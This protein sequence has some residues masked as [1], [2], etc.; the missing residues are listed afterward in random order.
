MRLVAIGRLKS[1][2]ERDLFERYA[3]RLR[4]A[5][6]VTELPPS[7]GSVLEQK[8][9]D[10]A[11]LLGACPDNAIVVAL[12][13]GGKALSSLKFAAMMERWQDSG[14]PIHFLIGGAEGLDSSVIERA[15]AVLSLGALTWPHMLVR[16]MIAE[17]I[18][19]AQAINT[20][21]PYHRDTRPD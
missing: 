3:A 12:D 9:R 14:R 18:F 19:R 2:P 20:G 10:A 1:G 4:P 11:A 17:Q 8:R 21:H 15:D 6:E 5:L 16:T 13:E 7:K